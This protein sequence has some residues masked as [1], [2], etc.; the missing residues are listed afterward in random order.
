M[1]HSKANPGSVSRGHE[2]YAQWSFNFNGA[3]IGRSLFVIL[4]SAEAFHNILHLHDLLILVGLGCLQPL[5]CG[6]STSRYTFKCCLST[7]PLKQDFSAMFDLES[8][9]L[10]F[11]RAHLVALFLFVVRFN[12][13]GMHFLWRY[14]TI[15]LRYVIV[16]VKILD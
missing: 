6:H 9:L 7:K 13:Q 11:P 10:Q 3:S 5:H 16:L 8:K 12:G 4:W 2:A 15:R 14:F 1:W